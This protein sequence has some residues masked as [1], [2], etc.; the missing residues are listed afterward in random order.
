MYR[1]RHLALATV[2]SLTLAACA[3]GPDHVAPI[4]RAAAAGP[5]VSSANPD[6]A[7]AFT[8]GQ[9]AGQ[10]WQLYQD[11]VL[12]TL[13]ADAFAHNTDLRAA[14][15]NLALA[16]ARL[17]EVGAGRLPD[18]SIG[19]GAT[20]GR[21]SQVQSLPGLDRTNAI[22]DVGIGISYE[23]D[24]FG[25]VSRSIE[26]ATGDAEAVAAMRDAVRVA[27]A[28]ETARAYADAGAA[29]ERIAVAERTVDIIDRTLTVTTK[30]F[31][32]GR[33]TRLDVARV[34]AL[35][36]QQ[37]AALPPLRAE[38]E[39]ALFRLATLTGRAP[40]ELPPEAGARRTVLR[41]DAA[42]PV[43]D[44]QSLIARRPDVREA[45]RRLAAETARIGVATAE[46]YPKISFGASVG[47]TGPS[48]GDL[49][50]GG[51]LRWLL[52]PLLSWGFPNQEANRARIAQ[53]DAA[54]VRALAEF[55]GAVLNALRETETAL[56]NYAHELDRRVALGDA[57]RQAERAAQVA[58]LQLRE[59]KVD[60]L[61]VLDA[62]R[63]LAVIETDL[64]ASDAKVTTTQVD[65][66][67]ALGGGWQ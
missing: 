30:R 37:R 58:R 45:E 52:G 62:E 7:A 35:R 9:P 66:F 64:A 11:P 65:L 55:D 46:L 27:V 61:A 41:L 6:L 50:T 43:G 42:I 40:A 59:G 13:V 15:A 24:L 17:R 54:A 23:V 2:G 22:F 53:A 56:S 12:D 60:S 25:R 34:A 44:G 39:G 19:A 1:F 21:T 14:T 4:P 63:S 32:A 57:R 38:R 51:P 26:A 10:W 5:F 29:A 48:L 33:G 8:T 16:R 3:V 28:A 36:D 67:R 18:T 20:Y 49:F 31:E 47:A